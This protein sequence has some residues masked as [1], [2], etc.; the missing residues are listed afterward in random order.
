MSSHEVIQISDFQ[1]QFVKSRRA[2]H[3]LLKQNV[4]GE[5]I[6]TCPR[7]CSKMMAVAF[8]KTQL[9]WIQAHVKYAP[10]EVVFKWGDVV[11]LLGQEYTI[12]HGSNAGIDGA[13]LVVSGG[14]DFCHRRVCSL[15]Q[16]MLLPYIQQK[17]Q[18]FSSVIN[19]KAERITLRNTSSRW[20]SCSSKKT[21][22]F[23]WKIA[24]APLD[25]VDYLIAHEVAHLKEMNHSPRFWAVV[26]VMT[27]KRKV[28][29]R[30]LKTNGRHLQ[31][32]R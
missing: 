23:C 17:V 24:F 28:A 5:I 8:A 4:K 10:K 22:S 6:L 31:A 16:K 12:Q 15:A 14:A 30:W 19:V 18:E 1:I 29:E 3:I 13:V 11:T 26:D 32:I 9:P 25:V 27:N 2:K 7:L 20:G 21:L